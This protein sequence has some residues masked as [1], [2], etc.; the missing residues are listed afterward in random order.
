MASLSAL[1][2]VM[3]PFSGV[4]VSSLAA[5]AKASEASARSEVPVSH[6]TG[7][8]GAEAEKAGSP[9][10]LLHSKGHATIG[11]PDV[12]N[13]SSK[14]DSLPPQFIHHNGKTGTEDWLREYGVWQMFL[15]SVEYLLPKSMLPTLPTESGGS[16]G[17]YFPWKSIFIVVAAG[18]MGGTLCLCLVFDKKEQKEQPSPF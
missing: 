8:R 14:I 9:L 12:S 7:L 4:S 2:L 18:I 10:A 6:H 16:S 5:P 1:F 13:L 3:L 11:P 15:K 17:A